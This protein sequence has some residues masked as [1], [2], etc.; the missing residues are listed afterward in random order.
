MT[1]LN[2]I[3]IQALADGEGTPEAASHTAVCAA[4]TAR[5]RARV[6]LMG[7]IGQCL[8]VPVTIRPA[9]AQ[10]VD[11]LADG[12]ATARGPRGTA[13]ATRLRTSSGP[14]SSGFRPGAGSRWAYSVAAVAA[15]TV[16]AVLFVAPLTKGPQATVSASEILA[17]SA[18]QLSAVVSSGIETL[19]YEMV[20]D[21]VPR[22]MMPD[23]VD[24]TYRV[25]QAID[26]AVP[27]RFRVTSYAA[28]G[29][30][31]TSVAQDPLRHRRVMAFTIE[32]QPFR[33]DV[34]LPP[35]AA[36]ISLPEMERLHMQASIAM[37]QAS[38]N[39]LLETIDGPNGLM[40]RVEVPRVA[41]PAANPVWDLSEARVLI[42]A[43]DFRVAE[44][45]VRGSFLKQPY[46]FSY[47]LIS[48]VMAARV[49]SDA[50]DVPQQTGE[51]VITGQGSN[52]P[53]HDVVVLALGELAKRKQ[54]Q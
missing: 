1:C 23:H 29:Q 26:H 28:D 46:S 18:T 16:V 49:A 9:L 40:Y 48:H 30:L 5:L 47:K 45:S 43:R 50:F 10:S 38:G 13:G 41:D 34:A 11:R 33:F 6:Q 15:A 21:G 12:L 37:M 53:M 4:C 35:G 22:E 32:G 52:I 42:D 44:F 14:V 31:V 51:I 54:A 17:K 19:E 8:D 27:G 20:L 39:Q 25:R 24:G 3:H 2:D 36:G 7:A